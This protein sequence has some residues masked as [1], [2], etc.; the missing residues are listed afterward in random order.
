MLAR[1]KI[2]F[3][4]MF[5][6]LGKTFNPEDL[7][8]PA[9]IVLWLA[10]IVFSL[11]FLTLC[12][13]WGIMSKRDSEYFRE[14]ST[15]VNTVRIYRIE[16]KKN[17]VTFFDL[18][19]LSR[20]RKISL[21]DFYNSFPG[22]EP[23]RVKSWVEDMLAEKTTQ[24]YL[25]TTV[26]F[27]KSKKKLS[28]F[29]HVRKA[30]PLL[31]V[32]HLESYL[33][34]ER[35]KKSTIGSYVSLS[36]ESDFNEALRNYNGS[37]GTTFCYT[38]LPASKGGKRKEK[39]PAVV[40][41]RLRMV[42]EPF[43]KGSMKLI[44]ASE[45]EYLIANFE[46][47]DSTEA[48]AFALSTISAINNDLINSKISRHP[49]EVRVGI[50][51]NK[52]LLGDGD[53]IISSA[54]RTARNAFDTASSIAFFKKGTEDYSQSE[55]T[56]YRSEVDRIICERK[57]FYFFRPVYG[58]SRK[59]IVGFLGK[60]A[61]KSDC[62]FETI[63]ELK[64]YA[65]RA[66]DDK[67]LFAA[68]AKNLV[69][70]FNA[71]RELKSQKLYFP[72]RP[73]E[74]TLIPSFFKRLKGAKEANLVF[75]F[76]AEEVAHAIVSNGLDIILE[77]IKAVKEAGYGVG[78]IFSGKTLGIEPQLLA[79]GDA[80]F[81]DFAQ[82]GDDTGLDASIRSQLHALVEKLL[83]YKKPIIGSN[84]ANWNSLEL[85]V[86]SGIDYISS[87]VFSPYTSALSPINEKNET[88]I[89]SLKGTI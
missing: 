8:D 68:I 16:S 30:E 10:L 54:R 49:I 57:I 64:N 62:A 72:S 21:D 59:R 11:L 47:W 86:G 88:R 43:I 82:N 69:N 42:L 44:Q 32:I 14:M 34:P 35:K 33:L 18:G 48:I 56:Q 89:L 46:Q 9:A 61:P 15:E 17:L 53:A 83:K 26:Y 80:F 76:K 67:N 1:V 45:F 41:F 29:L 84:L 60:A 63:D 77:N 20:Q 38:L 6:L 4:M 58:V 75:I 24:D 81:V 50:V 70:T 23:Q 36:S 2:L 25:P 52:D 19:S 22:N 5:S 51:S 85:V 78:Y 28:S 66:K 7:L 12:I 73:N 71:Q 55:I 31:G 79:L 87:D 3:V 40:S 39:I 37:T 74:L 65:A 13:S 27:K